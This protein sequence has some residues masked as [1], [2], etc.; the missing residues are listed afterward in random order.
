MSRICI[1]CG[2][3][4][5][6]RN[7]DYW[8]HYSEIHPAYTERNRQFQRQRNSRKRKSSR[9]DGPTIA[10]MDELIVKIDVIPEGCTIWELIYSIGSLLPLGTNCAGLILELIIVKARRS[11]AF[12][13]S[14]LF[15]LHMVFKRASNAKNRFL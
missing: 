9:K 4:W 2:R 5:R 8:R 15:L 7:P 13:P 12:S 11:Y 10:N 1:F 14:L 3:A 6:Q